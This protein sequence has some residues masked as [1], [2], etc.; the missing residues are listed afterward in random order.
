MHASSQHIA[1]KVHEDGLNA[2]AVQPH[3]ETKSATRVQL[4]QGSGLTSLPFKAATGVLDQSGLVERRDD[5][6]DSCARQVGLASEVRFGGGLRAPQRLQQ[7]A[8]VI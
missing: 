2:G 4:N 1:G 6:A 8:L 5:A 3:A 7:Q